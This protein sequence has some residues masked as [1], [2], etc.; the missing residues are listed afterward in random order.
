M[1][2]VHHC[3]ICDSGNVTKKLGLFTPFMSHRMFEY[4]LIQ[5]SDGS[6]M[7]FLDVFTNAI[8]CDDCGAVFS[9]MRPDADELA[10]VYE[11]YRGPDYNRIRTIFEPNYPKMSAAI[12][13]DAEWKNRQNLSCAFLEDTVNPA[14]IHRILD[15]GGDKGQYIPRIFSG[16]EKFV[17]DISGVGVVDGVQIVNDLAAVGQVDFVMASNI[18]EHVSYP[19]EVMADILKA[20]SPGAFVFIDVPQES[21][22]ETTVLDFH[23]HINF[24]TP[25]SVR[26]LIERMG[27]NLLKVSIAEINKGARKSQSIFALAQ[28]G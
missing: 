10:R 18:L 13:S 22:A 3:V 9:Q 11:G 27:L 23:E 12:D 8:W 16:S 14:T 17:Y 19:Q 15:Y 6:G 2:L 5:V 21:P 1:K 24:F 28:V 4:P 26:R 20:C 7:R 25:V